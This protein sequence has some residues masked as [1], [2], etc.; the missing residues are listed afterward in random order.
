MLCGKL[1]NDNYMRVQDTL[2]S[3]YKVLWEQRRKEV[4]RLSLELL[5]EGCQ[6]SKRNNA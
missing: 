3:M 4:L 2:G 1:R 5:K 6:Q